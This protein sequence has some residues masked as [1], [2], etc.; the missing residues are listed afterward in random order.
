MSLRL[1]LTA[2]FVVALAPAGSAGAAAERPTCS[3]KGSKT[4]ASNGAARVFTVVSGREEYGDVLYGCL[5]SVGRRI[6]LAEEFD[7]GLYQSSTF[8]KVRLNGRFV[9]WQVQHIDVSCKADCPPA[10]SPTRVQID[11]A[12]LRR[13]R[14][15]AFA[16]S[17]RDSLFVTRTG[18]PAWLEDG[19]GGIEVHAGE[20]VLDIGA[21]DS[22]SLAGH[23]L[24]WLNS[25]QR[26]SATLR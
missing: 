6:R 26:K 15:K 22:L 17:A 19:V 5:R 13:R 4:V 21:I 11:V 25:G 12:D 1:L 23:E 7:D 16:G 24:S 3:L 10:Y 20:Q 14:V 9:V 18:T 2:L 8:E